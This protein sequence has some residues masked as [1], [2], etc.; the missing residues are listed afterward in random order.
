MFAG[1]TVP[2][3]SLCWSSPSVFAAKVALGQSLLGHRDWMGIIH[4]T[5]E[6]LKSVGLKKLKGSLIWTDIQ[7]L[8]FGFLEVVIYFFFP[9]LILKQIMR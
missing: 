7:V 1:Q 8:S 4:R 3:L 2:G 9:E 5:T 6:A